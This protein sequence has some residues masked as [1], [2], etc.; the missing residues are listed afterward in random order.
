M[1]FQIPPE[2]CETLRECFVNYSATIHAVY[3][4][5]L[6]AAFTFHVVRSN[7]RIAALEEAQA[8]Q[9]ESD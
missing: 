5:L 6:S 3:S 2:G 4:T 7:Q 1:P 9:L 8:E